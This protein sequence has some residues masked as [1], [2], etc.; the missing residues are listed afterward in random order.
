MIAK[1]RFEYESITLLWWLQK[2]T[3]IHI[4]SQLMTSQPNPSLIAASRIPKP[5]GLDIISWRKKHR[6]VGFDFLDDFPHRVRAFPT[7]R[8]GP[9]ADWARQVANTKWTWL[10]CRWQRPSLPAEHHWAVGDVTCF[11]KKQQLNSLW[12]SSISFRESRHEYK[13][14]SKA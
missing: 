14:P 3:P 13:H 6:D 4:P 8:I 10:R 7:Q 12:A 1:Q 11:H 5:A 9:R 2:S